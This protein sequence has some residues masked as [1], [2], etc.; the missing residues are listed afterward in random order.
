MPEL[1]IWTPEEMA[2]RAKPKRVRQRENRERM[3]AEYGAQF[4]NVSP[5]F[6]GQ[7]TLGDEEDKR[8]VRNIIREAAKNQNITLRFRPIK[9]KQRIE[10]WVIDPKDAPAPRKPTGG[11][12]GRPR[13]N[14]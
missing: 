10:F 11:R 3:L 7:V 5:G 12:R 4:A 8:K 13:R 6:G 9:D 2:D 14:K 1:T